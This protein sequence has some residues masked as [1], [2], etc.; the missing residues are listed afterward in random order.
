MNEGNL[1]KLLGSAA[2]SCGSAEEAE[3]IRKV[4]L[5]ADDIKLPLELTQEKPVDEAESAEQGGSKSLAAIIR[6]LKLPGKIKLALLGN[7][8]ARAVLIR[9]SNRMISQFVLENPRLTENEVYEFARNKDLDDAIIRAIAVNNSWMK[10][11]SIKW[12]IISNPKT[13]LDISVSWCKHLKE[14]ELRLLAKSK[15]IPQALATQ[16]R[17]LLE[18]RQG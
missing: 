15:N 11:Y 2:A 6:D 3:T 4:G 10:N 7:Q 5:G 13:P 16:C 18:K 1:N 12:A 9:D 17:K 8:T 14:K